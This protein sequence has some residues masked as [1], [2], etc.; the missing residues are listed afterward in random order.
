MKNGLPEWEANFL[1]YSCEF[2][3]NSIKSI[4]IFE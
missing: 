3:K 2:Y 4:D 1:S